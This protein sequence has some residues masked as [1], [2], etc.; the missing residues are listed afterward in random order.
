MKRRIDQ[1]VPAF[2]RGDA[3]GHEAR[4]LRHFFR[5]QGFLSEIYCL[6]RDEGLEEESRLFKE[7]QSGGP[8][9][10]V[11]LHFA[12]PSPLSYELMK[13]PSKRVI[14]HHNVT[15]P[16]FFIG[17]SQEMVRLASLGKKELRQLAP[18]VDLG[19]ADS[20][21]NRLEL[22]TAGFR[23]TAVLPLFIDFDRYSRR[24]NPFLLK[25]YRDGR[26]NLLFVGRIVPNKK[27]E[28]LIK[29]TFYY[30]KYIS[31]LVRLIVVGKTTSLPKY[32]ESLVRLIDDFYLQP[33]EVLFT[34]HVPDED[35]YA[36]YQ[37]ADVFVS[38]SEH[39]GFCLP[40]IESMIYDVPVIAYAAG[41]VPSTLDG[42]GI[43]LKE[44]KVA[45]IAELIYFLKQNDNL[46][47]KIIQGQRERL[48][49]FR[50]FP[51]ENYLLSLL[52]N[53]GSK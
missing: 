17:F 11:I 9:D 53:L 42:A 4:H 28:D 15:S 37:L 39:E 21:Y 35:L 49:R 19:L 18:F 50:S 16:E 51:R 32:Y 1:W 38:L 29:V 3:I 26:T 12:L 24:A 48:A 23:R 20:E 30:K 25:V 27:I 2:H 22:E 31:P 40:L 13:V 46:R 14:I 45:E 5:N 6:D 41:A 44:K 8:E 33:E 47:Q 43:L 10:I 7:F 34:G 36:Y 52:E